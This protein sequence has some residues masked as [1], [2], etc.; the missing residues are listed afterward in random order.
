MELSITKL[1]YIT[2]LHQKKNR[3]EQGLFIAEG[4]KVI[5]DL[6][7]FGFV[8]QM[9]V[10]NPALWDLKDFGQSHAFCEYFTANEIQD[11]KLS[12]LSTPPGVIAVFEKPHYHLD[13][14]TLKDEWTFVFDQ[15]NDPGNLGTIIRTAHW[16]GLANIY[17]TKGSVEVFSPKVVQSSMGSLAAVKVH[18]VESE[19]FISQMKSSGISIYATD[20]QGE[21]IRTAQLSK[22]GCIVFGNEANGLSEIWKKSSGLSLTIE[23]SQPDDCPES[24][25]LSVSAAIVM[26]LLIR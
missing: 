6:I 21:S 20:M 14:L 19:L 7:K 3:E 11:K 17:V 23:P 15:I 4:I 24:L 8:P 2:S 25:N 9:I 12:L 1:K 10:Y 18:V 13:P 5:N 26:E 16:Y 22:P